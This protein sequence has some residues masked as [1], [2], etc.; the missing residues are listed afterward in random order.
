MF[1]KVSA[2]YKRT[3]HPADNTSYNKSNAVTVSSTSPK[4][5][6]SN[7]DDIALKFKQ[8]SVFQHHNE[9]Q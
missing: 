5:Q 1:Q 3:N 8:I 9:A 6:V 2:V 7:F 4:I